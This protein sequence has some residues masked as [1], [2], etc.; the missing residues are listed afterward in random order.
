M[1]RTFVILLLFG[2]LLCTQI[3]CDNMEPPYENIIPKCQSN[4]V[5]NDNNG[6]RC[7]SQTTGTHYR[8]NKIYKFCSRSCRKQDTFL[9]MEIYEF[10]N[11]SDASNYLKKQS[12]KIRSWEGWTVNPPKKLSKI[13]MT[14]PDEFYIYTGHTTITYLEAMLG[15][16]TD[17]VAWFV[18]ECIEF[19]V[20]TTVGSYNV[21][22]TFS[23]M[24]DFFTFH[25]LEI[26]EDCS[27]DL[28]SAANYTIKQLRT[29]K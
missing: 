19:R 14:K 20:G 9:T 24:N 5:V 1:K 15:R 4:L 2:F 3:S 28:Y 7:G 10:A 27:N 23:N 21:N 12:N 25:S 13:G 16:E 26:R 18:T 22:H 6:Q 11:Q 8:D 29:V 17:I